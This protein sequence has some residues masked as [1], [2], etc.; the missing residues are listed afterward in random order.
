M[1]FLSMQS[2]HMCMG[3]YIVPDEAV[4]NFIPADSYLVGNYAANDQDTRNEVDEKNAQ[5]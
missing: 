3:V 2:S 4:S 5:L 1:V